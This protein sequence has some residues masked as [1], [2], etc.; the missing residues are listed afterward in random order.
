M[1]SPQ[2]PNTPPQPELTPA[3]QRI[4]ALLQEGKLDEARIALLEMIVA[5]EPVV[6]R[7]HERMVQS[8]FLLARVLALLG[9]PGK[10]EE[11]IGP[12]QQVPEE[13]PQR[14]GIFLNARVL[15]ANLRRNQAR[16]EEAFG[17]SGA[18]LDQLDQSAGNPVNPD[19][20]R[21]ILQ[22]V[23]IALEAGQHQQAL[24]LCAKGIERFQ[25][26]VGEAH[27]HLVLM[28][29]AVFLAAE[30]YDK[31]REHFETI[32]KQAVEQV[33]EENELAVRAHRYLGQ[34]EADLDNEGKAKEHFEKCVQV[35]SKGADP[36]LIIE[37][38]QHRMP[39]MLQAMEPSEAL[40]AVSGYLELVARVHGP[41]SPK[42]AELLATLGYQHRQSGDLA[43]A[44]EIY[45]VALG[46]W[47]AWR[48]A[49]DPKIKLLEGIL[50]E[51]G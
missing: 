18:V 12:L 26:K 11:A 9:E 10:A 34:L 48:P 29:G 42:V 24:D 44:K 7:F 14:G 13:D 45:E 39:L 4:G 27:A 33:G 8:R 3:Q 43:K 22:M 49:E 50:A 17:L 23:Q 19:S 40:Q 1:E 38:E 30:Q 15:M 47:R 25:D 21:T 37:V 51:I 35:L 28:A 31:A 5:E 32:L 41:R 2:E 6:G 20:F 36:E 16:Y 46:I